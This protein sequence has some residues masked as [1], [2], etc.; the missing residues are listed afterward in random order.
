VG[1]GKLLP[2]FVA[3]PIGVGFLMPLLDKLRRDR[4]LDVVAIVASLFLFVLTV[5][6]LNGGGDSVY[7]M[8][9]WKPTLLE[10]KT[11]LGICLVSDGLSRLLVL[12]VNAVAF[13]VVIFSSDYMK[14]YTNRGLFYSLFFLMVA[15]MNGVVLTGDFF[16]LYV[17]LEVASIA[18]YALVAF[19]CESEE[20]EASFK[21]LVLGAIGTLLVL[22]GVALL[23]GL[24]GT[25]NMG[26]VAKILASGETPMSPAYL[27]LGMFL[28][29]FGVKAAMVP[30]HAW[31]PDAHPSAPAPISAMLSGVLIKAV[32]VYVLCRIVFNVFV[33]TPA[34]VHV[35]MAL[36]VTSMVA[37]GFL[38]VGQWDLKRLL[39]YSSISHMGYVVLAVGVAGEVLV[40]DGS[41]ALASLALFG[42]LFHLLNHATFKSLL[43]LCSGAIECATGTR[44][45]K[46]LGG[47]G[48]RMPVTSG[49]TR[50]ASLSIAGVPPFNGFWS[51]LIIVIAV[52]WAGHYWLAAVTVLVSFV[53]LVTFVKVQRY[54]VQG[55]PSGKTASAREVSAGMTMPMVVLATLCVV[56]GLIAVLY[57]PFRKNVLDSAVDA[58]AGE[59]AG[60]ISK[61]QLPE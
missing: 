27:A 52:A 25:L 28:A 6:L 26:Q 38:M 35:L 8:G 58:M 39:A 29:G 4:I 55:E 14:R 57:G 37:G 19:G 22:T 17:F 40:K 45:L 13:L 51:K 53:T 49:C 30:F 16:N 9:D 23:Y 11:L 3:V 61:F 15:G 20:L 10:G 59:T 12:I 18:S 48:K 34:A 43:F 41:V 21:Y 60:Y 31:L 44:D 32:G 7:W 42:G 2:L 5:V 33:L 56:M 36:G 54:V 1:V 50:I 46:E 24:T 47:L